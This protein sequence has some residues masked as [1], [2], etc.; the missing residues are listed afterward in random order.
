MSLSNTI[1]VLIKAPLLSDNNQALSSAQ[2]TPKVGEEHSLVFALKELLAPRYETQAQTDKFMD[3]LRFELI[4][5]CCF[6]PSAIQRKQEKYLNAI[7]NSNQSKP[8]VQ[9][10]LESTNRHI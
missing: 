2:A 9:V 1:H 3:L 6:Y 4:Y 5:S 7:Q 8:R 10:I